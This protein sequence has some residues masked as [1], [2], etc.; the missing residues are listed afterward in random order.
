MTTE[1][2]QEKIEQHK[3]W[4]GLIKNSKLRAEQLVLDE[5]DLRNVINRDFPI[6]HSYLTCCN[7]S[8]INFENTDF[9]RAELYSSIFNECIFTECNFY[10]AVLNY[11]EMENA[12]FVNCKFFRTDM[13]ETNFANSK[14]INCSFSSAGFME[15]NL[16]NVIFE[17]VDFN[18]AYLDKVK[19][20]GSFFINNQNINSTSH[21]SLDISDSENEI[22][23]IDGSE[24]IDWIAKHSKT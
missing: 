5:V 9:Y 18:L 11:C 2:L 22:K 1:Q 14:F 19:I 17:N 16:Q 12:K 24:A 7:F 13:F 15:S 8:K 23:I 6:E 21:L 20:K 10:K 3:K 4:L